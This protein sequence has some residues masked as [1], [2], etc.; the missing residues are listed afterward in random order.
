MLSE[1]YNSNLKLCSKQ[2]NKIDLLHLIVASQLGG[3]WRHNNSTKTREAGHANEQSIFFSY[4]YVP[5]PTSNH[6]SQ[7]LFVQMYMFYINPS[8][9]GNPPI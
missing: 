1:L 2:D 3:G 9:V 6:G 7:L 4:V 8:I 5:N